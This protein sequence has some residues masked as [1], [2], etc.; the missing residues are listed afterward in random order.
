M[1]PLRLVTFTR[2]RGGPFGHRGHSYPS[3][4]PPC[5]HCCCFEHPTIAGATLLRV[6]TLWPSCYSEDKPEGR[7]VSPDEGDLEAWGTWEEVHW[8]LW[9]RSWSGS[10]GNFQWRALNHNI[11]GCAN[12]RANFGEGSRAM[13]NFYRML[14]K[15][16]GGAAGKR[17]PY[18]TYSLENVSRELLL[19]KAEKWS[20]SEWE[21]LL[22]N[23][24][25][26]HF[27]P[28]LS[29]LFAFRVQGLPGPPGPKLLLCIF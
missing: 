1:K 5:H 2:E 22:V 23:P 10:S 12:S 3:S 13:L 18:L 26:L 9:I 16:D 8:P 17:R 4:I 28:T 6:M 27:A 29:P 7:V 21:G 25:A 24:R 20:W 19:R 15:R 14:T 11:H